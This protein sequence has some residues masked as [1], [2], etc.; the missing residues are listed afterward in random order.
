MLAERKRPLQIL[1]DR[2]TRPLWAARTLEQVADWTFLTTLLVAAWMVRPSAAS[3]GIVLLARIAPRL[4][5]L[6]LGE[7]LLPV[8]GPA[9]LATLTVL[10]ALVA[11]ALASAFVPLDMVVLA[12][13]ALVSGTLSAM[14]AETR[15]GL[16]PAVVAPGGLGLAGAFD[17]LLERAALMAGPLI[18]TVVLVMAGPLPAFGVAAG[19]MTAAALTYLGVRADGRAAGAALD[20]RD[21]SRTALP[22]A[23]LM[24]AVA[25]FV[26]GAIAASLL[27]ALMPII[28]LRL[29]GLPTALGLGL[30]AV[31][32]GTL[33]GPLAVPR[34]MGRL[35]ASVLMAG[36]VAL[37]AGATI[38][39]AVVDDA[40]AIALA[41]VGIGIVGVTHDVVRAIVARRSAADDRF[42]AGTRLVLLAGTGGQ[43]L[44][45]VVPGLLDP[46]LGPAGGL[47][48]VTVAS[49]VTIVVAA[50]ATGRRDP[51]RHR[52][53]ISS[54]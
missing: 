4:L 18:A 23:L 5:V 27:V 7:R 2:A 28:V 49:L 8:L 26:T 22:P 48:A 39:V 17:A 44:G 16:L 29:D 14:S 54:T 40:I 13:G 3:V 15:A 51:L 53:S 24:V 6:V 10:R 42:L 43:C 47:A 38:V 36:L 11:A 35:P 45:A 52:G 12:A 9:G 31:G 46:S 30:A 33:I 50:L 37:S 19:L 34:L 20:R 32:L 21:P 25:A 1:S 41:L